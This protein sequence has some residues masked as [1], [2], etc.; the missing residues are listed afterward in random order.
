MS[1]TT[2]T[3]ESIDK[4]RQ[5]R[6][7]VIELHK[8]LLNG[9]KQL[10]EAFQTEQNGLGYHSASIEQLLEDL[11]FDGESSGEPVKKLTRKLKGSADTRQKHLDEN[12]YQK[13]K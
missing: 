2:V 12:N 10:A 3:Q 1:Y 9:T 6:L 11:A 8:D 7:R 5:M 4:L 13:S